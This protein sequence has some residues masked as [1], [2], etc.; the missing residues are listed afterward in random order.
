MREFFASAVEETESI[1][2]RLGKTLVKGDV[3]IL[4]GEPGAGKT[5]FTRGIARGMGLKAQV[6]SPTFT[7]VREY[8]NRLFHF[9]LY[10]IKDEDELFDIDFES[11]LTRGVCVIEWPEPAMELLSSPICVELKYEK[12]G[13]LIR[14]DR[15]I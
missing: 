5:A 2:E 10:R 4:R 12:E 9:D 8:E 1:G 11:Y 3:V 15:D 7:I 14:L 6:K 13:R